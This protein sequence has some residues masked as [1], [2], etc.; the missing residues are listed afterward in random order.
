M[1]VLGSE[2][3]YHQPAAIKRA[4][5]AQGQLPPYLN[6]REA[7][8]FG[9]S[10]AVVLAFTNNSQLVQIMHE[11]LATRH[12]LHIQSNDLD[13]AT[14]MVRH[15]KPDMVL[16]DIGANIREAEHIYRKLRAAHPS[17][18]IFITHRHAS[19]ADVANLLDAGGDDVLRLSFDP[20]EL[21]AR[22]RVLLRWDQRNRSRKHVSLRLDHSKKMAIV[23][24]KRV[25]LTPVEFDLLMLLCS[26]PTR[27]FSAPDLLRELWNYT[28]RSGDTALVR[29]HIRNL[30]SKLESDPDRPRVIVSQYGRGYTV[31]ANVEMV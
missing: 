9:Y 21:T 30:R 15:I 24:Q 20:S 12:Q 8:T 11:A 7:F 18:V 2:C 26:N 31:D 16:A 23:N 19:A 4:E 10:M 27:Y 25:R 17:L 13:H 1:D 29:N 5:N 22:V 6:I 28:P 3:L 14:R